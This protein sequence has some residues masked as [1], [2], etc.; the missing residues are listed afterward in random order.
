MASETKTPI[1][2]LYELAKQKGFAP[3]NFEKY[4]YDDDR[5]RDRHE[6]EFNYLVTVAGI[7][8]SGSGPS[9]QIAK[10]N[11]ALSL[12]SI[13][14]HQDL[15]KISENP[16][17]KFKK[18]GFNTALSYIV[19]LHNICIKNKIP[20]PEFKETFNVGP[21]HA[22]EFTFECRV[23]SKITQGTARSK[24]MAKQLAAKGML[25]S[26]MDLIGAFNAIETAIID[27]HSEVV[28]TNNEMMGIIPDKS[29]KL[30]EMPSTSKKLIHNK[31]LTTKTTITVLLEL[32]VQKGLA[33]PVFQ[34]VLCDSRTHET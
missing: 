27:K 23:A 1:T 7:S 6:I 17:A 14:K 29:V 32:T 18:C 31:N 26:H 12:L 16:V 10:H 33:P 25:E 8:S 24:K 4:D 9:K 13:L 11:A 20:S 19:E 22:M 15:Y 28:P 2:V 3:P 21:P 34:V 5:C 30:D